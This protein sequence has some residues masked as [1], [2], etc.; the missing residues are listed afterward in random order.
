[1]SLG[2][3]NPNPA[4]MSNRCFV[5]LATG[6]RAVGELIQDLGEDIE[7]VKVPQQDLDRLIREGE[8]DHAIVLA[9]IA[10]WRAHAAG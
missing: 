4:M 10:L 3:N 5:Y 6:C 9:T 2:S 1:V 8:I 7:V